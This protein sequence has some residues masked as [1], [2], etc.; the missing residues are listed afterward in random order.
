M[1]KLAGTSTTLLVN[2]RQRMTDQLAGKSPVGY[3]NPPQHTRFK[4]GQS[5][6]PKGRAKGSKN[7]VTVLLTSAHEP[8]TVN[9]G[10]Q[11][12]SITKL[13]AMAKQLANKAASGDPRATQLLMQML[14]ASA[15]PPP[16]AAS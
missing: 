7:L 15:S 2:G 12:K 14:K 10:G 16:S 3:R 8:V 11:R 5:G 1:L 6:N 4:K 13:E 9:E